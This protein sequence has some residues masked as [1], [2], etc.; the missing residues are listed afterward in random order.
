MR[1]WK[2]TLL[3][4]GRATSGTLSLAGILPL[5]GLTLKGKA[6]LGFASGFSRLMCMSA[7]A[8]LACLGCCLCS[9]LGPGGLNNCPEDSYMI[10]IPYFILLFMLM[11]L[12]LWDFVLFSF[13][14]E[15][16]SH[17]VVLADLEL[18]L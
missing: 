5:R 12:V 8:P 17:R 15:T 11:N 4:K 13:V 14:C 1:L 9:C 18:T 7:Q 6:A 2:G 10:S 16:G 3:P